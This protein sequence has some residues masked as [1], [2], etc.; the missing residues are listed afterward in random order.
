MKAV[1]SVWRDLR[2]GS[3]M[4]LP[5]EKVTPWLCKALQIPPSMPGNKLPETGRDKINSSIFSGG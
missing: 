5:S 1:A 4:I 3:L 2:C